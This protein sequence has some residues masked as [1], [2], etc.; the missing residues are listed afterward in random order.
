[1]RRIIVAVEQA[2]NMIKGFNVGYT[3][4][5]GNKLMMDYEGSRYLIT[6]TKIEKPS[7]NME[8]DIDRFI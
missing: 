4:R 1:M 2:L 6:F 7:E 3:T 5:V 8:D